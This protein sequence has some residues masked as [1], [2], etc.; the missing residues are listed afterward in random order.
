VKATTA[1][2]QTQC[3]P[4]VVQVVDHYPVGWM[5]LAVLMAFLW[6]QERFRDGWSPRATRTAKKPKGT[7]RKVSESIPAD[8]LAA[9]KAMGLSGPEAQSVYT[10]VKGYT[11]LEEGVKLALSL[12][13]KKGKELRS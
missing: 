1:Q 7:A 8:F 9:M 13:Y 3:P 2:V 10:Q 11:T 5:L 12:Q 4:P 6:L